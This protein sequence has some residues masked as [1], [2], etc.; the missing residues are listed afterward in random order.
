MEKVLH[1][2]HDPLC[3]WCYGAS[4]LTE[5]AA[6]LAPGQFEIR[7]H[8]G[9]L[10]QRTRLSDANRA[11]IRSA[12]ARI[13][14]ITGQAFGQAYLNGLLGDPA[15]VYD[16]SLPIRGI[17]AADTVKP[18]SG[19]VM[20]KALQRAHYQSGLRIVEMPTIM[21]MAETSGLDAEQFA[22]AF[23]TIGNNELTEHLKRTHEFMRKMGIQGYPAFVAQV[24]PHYEQ[25]PHDRFY[26]NAEA[27]AEQ[28]ARV[29]VN[30]R[31]AGVPE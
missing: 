28:V 29:L 14:E 17:L 10:F 6:S 25:L 5:A 16:S 26:G 7:L 13:G 1:Y 12:D 15:T 18:G 23:E 4:A 3:G 11:H 20:L 30:K 21:Q 8:A 24:G 27:F 31:D 2:I 9:G 22:R 19:L